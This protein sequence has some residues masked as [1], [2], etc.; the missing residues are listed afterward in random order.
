MF[1]ILIAFKA[2]QNLSMLL[3]CVIYNQ[4]KAFISCGYKWPAEGM[5]E[6]HV[7]LWRP[8]NTPE[9]EIKKHGSRIWT[10]KTTKM[11][12]A[13]SFAILAVSAVVSG[14]RVDY[15]QLPTQDTTDTFF[16]GTTV[17]IPFCYT[18]LM[19]GARNP[20]K[21]KSFFTLDGIPG[22][23]FGARKRVLHAEFAPLSQYLDK[24]NYVGFR[25]RHF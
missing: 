16:A 23:F 25:W 15:L 17:N 10:E 21:D 1:T 7:Q 14:A 19:R 9:R 8:F 22:R 11:L 5:N 20:T 24:S 6:T 18:G 4:V 2:Y 12:F 13:T 3:H